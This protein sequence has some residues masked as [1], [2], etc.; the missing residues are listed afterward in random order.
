MYKEKREE[1]DLLWY[2]R[3]FPQSVCS[4]GGQA[5]FR[6][7]LPPICTRT[8]EIRSNG[9]SAHCHSHWKS[10]SSEHLTVGSHGWLIFSFCSQLLVKH[11]RQDLM[12]R[13]MIFTPRAS[14]SSPQPAPLHA[15]SSKSKD[16]PNMF[17]AFFTMTAYPDVSVEDMMSVLEEIWDV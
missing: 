11:D 4:S 6:D 12:I 14:F 10:T 9:S 1:G 3:P 8:I 13:S 5:L 15:T 16:H 7:Q 17:A 2:T